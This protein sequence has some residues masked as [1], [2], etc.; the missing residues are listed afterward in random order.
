MAAETG[1]LR[2]MGEFVGLTHYVPEFFRI[3]ERWI[4]R[5]VTEG[6]EEW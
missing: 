3:L 2:G 4:E 1:D 5:T 6:V